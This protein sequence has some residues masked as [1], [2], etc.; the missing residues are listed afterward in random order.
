MTGGA[1]LLI[2]AAAEPRRTV[3]RHGTQRNATPRNATRNGGPGPTAGPPPRPPAAG[4]VAGLKAAGLEPSHPTVWVME[5]IIGYLT[6][7][8]ALTLM[9]VRGHG[10]RNCAPAW[11]GTAQ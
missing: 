8:E 5:G 10:A 6:A 11:V 4:L 3:P 2:A 7:A 9:Q 1:H